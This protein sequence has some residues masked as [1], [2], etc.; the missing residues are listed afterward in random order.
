MGRWEGLTADEIHAR[1]PETFRDW[2][3]RNVAST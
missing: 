1:E 2:M 3:A